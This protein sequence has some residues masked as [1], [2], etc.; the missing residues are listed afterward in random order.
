[1][2]EEAHKIG[3]RKFVSPNDVVKG[4]HRLNLAFVANLFIIHPALQPPASA[5]H[6]L[7]PKDAIEQRSKL[8]CLY[9]TVQ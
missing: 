5:E 3:C 2:L 9:N 8:Y 1:M 7:D 4:S 6:K